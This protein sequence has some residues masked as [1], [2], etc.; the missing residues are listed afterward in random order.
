SERVA[1][2]VDIVSDRLVVYPYDSAMRPPNERPTA[3]EARDTHL[4][5]PFKLPPPPKLEDGT[6]RIAREL[7]FRI[8]TPPRGVV[9]WLAL[10]DAQTNDLLYLRPFR[11]HVAGMV[12]VREPLTAGGPA[13]PASTSTTLNP[14]RTTVTLPGLTAP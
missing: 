8:L 12:F 14:F 6:F 9:T 3:P 13:G 5:F 11:S 7:I 10:V 2:H 4:A 1:S